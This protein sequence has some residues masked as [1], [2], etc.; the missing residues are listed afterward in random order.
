MEQR[1]RGQTA[2][3]GRP[4][5]IQAALQL[6]ADQG[7]SGLSMRGLAARLGVTPNALYNHFRDKT[8]L[9]DSMLDDALGEVRTSMDQEPRQRLENIM[10]S[11][12]DVLASR[13]HLVPLYLERRGARGPNAVALGE[14]MRQALTRAGVDEDR[15]QRAIHV[16]IVQAI[17]FAAYGTALPDAVP[18][19]SAFIDSLNWTLDGILPH[20]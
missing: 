9:I 13:R 7:S 3:L 1:G 8:D 20:K 19:R 11:S 6:L 10:V 17:G 5:I 15:S 4:A 12:Y 2:G 16:L 18:N 14:R